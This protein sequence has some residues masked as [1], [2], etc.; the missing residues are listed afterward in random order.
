MN[1]KEFRN[2]GIGNKFIY[3][4]KVVLEVRKT[5]GCDD[6]YF[7]DYTCSECFYMANQGYIPQCSKQYR[8]DGN[9]VKFIE[10]K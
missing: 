4:E 9:D 1:E 8:E 3:K 10:V 6:C 5:R 2:L 7:R